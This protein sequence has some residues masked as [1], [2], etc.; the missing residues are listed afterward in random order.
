MTLIK[1]ILPTDISF[2]HKG[3]KLVAG[4]RQDSYEEDEILAY[5]GVDLGNGTY[6]QQYSWPRQNKHIGTPEEWARDLGVPYINSQIAAHYGGFDNENQPLP[7][8][9]WWTPYAKF[10]RVNYVFNPSVGFVLI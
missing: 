1:T 8:D 2:V 7:D 3:Q 9:E 10:F 5:I 4:F 6:D